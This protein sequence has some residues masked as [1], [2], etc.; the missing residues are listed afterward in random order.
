MNQLLKVN[1]GLCS[2][3][4]NE[5]LF[6]NLSPSQCIDVL[7]RKLKTNDVYAD[8]LEDPTHPGHQELL[9]ILDNLS[10]FSSWG[11]ARDMET[12]AKK[13]TMTAFTTDSGDMT[14]KTSSFSLPSSEVLNCFKVML[15]ER[16]T[17]ENMPLPALPSLGSLPPLQMPPTPAAPSPPV[18]LTN[19]KSS[20]APPKLAAEEVPTPKASSAEDSDVQR[21]PGV[22]DAIWIQ[23]KVAKAAEENAQRQAIEELARLEREAKERAI[24]AKAAEAKRIELERKAAQDAEAKRLWE[25]ERL[26]EFKVREALAKAQAA[27]E[28]KRREE[29]R[30]RKEEAKVQV[31]LRQMGV[32]VAGFQWI[33]MSG[34]YR[35][36]GGSHFVS[37]AQL[38]L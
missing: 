22:S 6:S 23:L 3:F 26:R 11:N 28:A 35:C 12:A 8:V 9:K 14:A 5:I 27:L 37:D 24:A 36:A 13:L 4:P 38:G 20:L 18:L 25:L 21:D 31:K 30:K 34:G 2:R 17:R 19:T 29:E 1:P 10:S 7:R 33:K 15:A 16:Q 32:C